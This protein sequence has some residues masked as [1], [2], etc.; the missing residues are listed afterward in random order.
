MCYF[1]RVS[2]TRD[3]SNRV[4]ASDEGRVE[5][6]EEAERLQSGLESK[7]PSFIKSMLQSHVSGGFWLVS[8]WLYTYLQQ[9]VML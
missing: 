2:K 1:F 4:Y 3:L 9:L 6:L 7:Y 8:I 5:A